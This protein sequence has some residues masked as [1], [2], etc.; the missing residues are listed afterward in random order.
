MTEVTLEFLDDFPENFESEIRELI[1]PM[2]RIVGRDLASLYLHISDDTEAAEI[3]VMRRYHSAHIYFSFGFFSEKVQTKRKVLIHELI[4][5]LVDTLQKHGAQI[6]DAYFEEGS[7]EHGLLRA[8]FEESSE[9][10][11]DA[12]A[13]A[14]LDILDE[15][16]DAQG[17]HFIH[18]FD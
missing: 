1:A 12:L 16:K 2:L 11:T 17:E 8:R 14:F 4:H 18:D 5:V 9:K 7:S 6:I 10:L 13:L 3:S 15:L